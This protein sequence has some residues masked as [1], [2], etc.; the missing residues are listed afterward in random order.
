VVRVHPELLAAQKIPP[1]L[2]TKNVWKERFEDIRAF[3]RYLGRNGV[4]ICKFFLYVS[5][6]EQKKRYLERLEDPDKN[7]KFSTSDA[8]EREHW[9]DYMTA[10][11][12]TIRSTATEDAPWYAVPADNK[13]FTRLVVCAAVIE[14]LARLDLGYPRVGKAKRAELAEARRMLLGKG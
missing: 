6:K 1:T 13:W 3:E 8:K 2:V 9:G 4:A 14:T 12:D 7:W 10:Y 5:K 11:E